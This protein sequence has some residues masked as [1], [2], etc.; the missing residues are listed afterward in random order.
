MLLTAGEITIN[1]FSII[2]GLLMMIIVVWLRYSHPD[3]ANTISFK[4]SFWIGFVDVLWRTEFILFKSNEIFDPIAGQDHWIPRLFLWLQH[5]L[6]IWAVLPSVCIAFD[7]QLTF[8]H[9]R[10]NLKRIQRWYIPFTFAFALLATL[11]YLTRNKVAYD[12]EKLGISSNTSLE[13]I[14]IT[15]ALSMTLGIGLSILYSLIVV[16]MV[17]VKVFLLIR[18]IKRTQNL[19]KET[20]QKQTQIITSVL[21]VLLYPVV[22]IITQPTGIAID[23]IGTLTTNPYLPAFI[24]VREIDN[25]LQSSIGIFNFL[26][27]LLNP[28][29]HRALRRLS[30]WPNKDK[31]RVYMDDWEPP[32]T[33]NVELKLR[34]LDE[35]E[36]V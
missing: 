13:N 19:S 31:S 34:A 21:R 33:S 2:C 26:V 18:Y 8:I 24:K 22:L 7:L 6:R 4:L 11:I 36:S 1:V 20:R 23:W 14:I 29:L 25:V 35:T 3:V 5:F 9:G 28:A 17:L 10:K 15:K 27:F 32:E 12:K 16:L 30:W